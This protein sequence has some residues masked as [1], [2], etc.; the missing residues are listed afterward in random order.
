MTIS[1]L[2]FLS[3]YWLFFLPIL[4]LYLMWWF[5]SKRVT[6]TASITDIDNALD[7]HFY[8]PLAH[9]LIKKSIAKTQKE[10]PPFWKKTA[11]WWQT[12]AI[13]LLLIALA[14]PILVGER[15]PDPPAERDI[16]FL[17]DTSLSMQLK[18][19]SLNGKAIKRMDLLKKLLDDFSTNMLGE[20]I[21]VIIFAENPYMLVPL[22][23]DQYLIRNML[24]RITTTLAGRYTAVGDALLMALKEAKKQKKR[25]QTFI[26]FTDA[27]ESRG[28]TDPI[29]A[30][31]LVAE[32]HIPIFTIAIGSSQKEAEQE[33][34]GGLYQAVNLPL[35]S[36]ISAT[37]GGRAY[38]VHDSKAIQ[39]AL[40][41]ILTQRKNLADIPP[42]YERKQLY[43]YPL[44]L[45]LLLLSLLQFV[46]L[47]IGSQSSLG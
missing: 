31:K 44:A 29:A 38:Q 3:A 6:N 30:A 19:Y 14:K 24:Q 26:L 42:Q 23:N 47:F 10:T 16:V 40:D 17:V 27:D 4:W 21:S 32:K 35:L 8:H 34:K 20:K 22:T 15:L 25:H 33:I 18:D 9:Q 7:Q 28:H 13:S 2:Q 11:F 36:K 43:Y 41:N 45:G 12:I 39:E 1:T 37:T 5:S 46:R